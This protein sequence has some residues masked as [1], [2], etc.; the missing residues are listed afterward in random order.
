MIHS[1]TKTGF[2]LLMTPSKAFSFLFF[3]LFSI[4]LFGQSRISGTIQ[5]SN[6][7]PIN[8]VEVYNTTSAAKAITDANG[9]FS[10]EIKDQ[11]ANQIILYK[12]GYE[13][14]ETTISSDQ[15]N[16]VFTLEKINNLSEVVI[17]NQR[18]KLFNL[19]R[20]RDV[21][22]TAIYAGKKTEVIA[23]SKLTANKAINNTRQIFGQVVGLTINEGS[24]GGLQE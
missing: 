23:I 15:N 7:T 8:G 20:L 16:V 1:N 13:L 21:E 3:L 11:V 17:Q 5:N 18:A 6:N 22:E 10:I 2:Y 14:V 4:T 12:E 19:N 9:M 24:E